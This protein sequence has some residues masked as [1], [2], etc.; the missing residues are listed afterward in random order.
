MKVKAILDKFSRLQA[1][2]IPTTTKIRKALEK[3]K[4]VE[5]NDVLANKLIGWNIVKK[6]TNKIKKK[7]EGDK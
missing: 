3:G 2:A 1:Q 7:K 4:S 5:I 6:V